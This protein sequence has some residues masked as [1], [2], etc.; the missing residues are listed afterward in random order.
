MVHIKVIH[1]QA[2]AASQISITLKV[3]ILS[4]FKQIM[5]R[6]IFIVR[7]APIKEQVQRQFRL[8]QIQR[9]THLDKYLKRQALKVGNEV[10]FK[11][12]FDGTGL[13][14]KN[15]Q[16]GFSIPTRKVSTLGLDNQRWIKVMTPSTTLGKLK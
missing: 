7:R 10:S 15:G 11:R 9:L 1:K 14:S 16:T 6:L 4:R 5:G 8:N 12:T 2:Q 3:K 13:D